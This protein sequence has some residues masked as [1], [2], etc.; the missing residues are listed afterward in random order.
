[1]TLPNPLSWENIDGSYHSTTQRPKSTSS[2]KGREKCL[3]LPVLPSVYVKLSKNSIFFSQSPPTP[4][5]LYIMCE[6]GA[7]RKNIKI[8]AKRVQRYEHFPNPQNFL[9]KKM[10]KITKKLIFEGFFLFIQQKFLPLSLK[11]LKFVVS[12][13]EEYGD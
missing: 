9:E 5:I 7:T 13:L 6:A 12:K 10:K 8:S 1:R 11:N 2:K 3:R 4:Y